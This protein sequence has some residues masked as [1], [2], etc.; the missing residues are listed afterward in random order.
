M[1][2]K[3]HLEFILRV[4]GVTAQKIKNA[5]AEFAEELEIADCRESKEEPKEF[6]INVNAEEPTVIF[7]ICAQFG[8]IKSV[9]IDEEHH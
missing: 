4:H 3:Y 1:Q 2:Q 6:K 7:D 5:L 9:R 8:R